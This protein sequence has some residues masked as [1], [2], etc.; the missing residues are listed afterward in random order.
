MSSLSGPWENTW[1]SPLHFPL[2]VKTELENFKAQIFL[3]KLTLTRKLP[4]L[5]G[6]PRNDGA[7]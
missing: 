5:Y 2:C 1:T 7:L 6:F 4:E 3:G